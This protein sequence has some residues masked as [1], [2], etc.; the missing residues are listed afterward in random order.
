PG[1]RLE[2]GVALYSS[3]KTR[4]LG[5]EE[6]PMSGER[7]KRS[8]WDRLFSIEYHS[9]REERVIEYITHRLGEGAGLQEILGEEY[10]RRNAS[11]AEVDEI[12]SNPR[13]VEAA[14][15]RMEQDFGSEELDP[16]RRPH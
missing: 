7:E 10:V 16:T 9:A 5:R 6:E 2:L 13:L 12:C 8:F 3:S 1:P 11:P 15:E 14:R 4:N